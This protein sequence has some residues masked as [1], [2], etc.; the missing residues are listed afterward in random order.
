MDS[1][2][3]RYGTLAADALDG[4]RPVVHDGE[5]HSSDDRIGIGAS[6]QPGEGDE[7]KPASTARG[8]V[9][10]EVDVGELDAHTREGGAH[11]RFGGA[12]VERADVHPNRGCT[13]L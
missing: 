12:H 13:S 7:G 1:L 8:P 2:D 11:I 10:D 4:E 3:F 9:D 6:R 5:S